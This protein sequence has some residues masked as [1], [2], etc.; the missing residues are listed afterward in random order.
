[1][2]INHESTINFLL[3]TDTY[4]E[5]N[6]FLNFHAAMNAYRHNRLLDL[7]FNIIFAHICRYLHYEGIKRAKKMNYS[8][9]AIA[10]IQQNQDTH[11]MSMENIE[12][13]IRSS[14]LNVIN[15]ACKANKMAREFGL[16][17]FLQVKFEKTDENAYRISDAR[18]LAMDIA[19]AYEVYLG[20]SIIKV[21]WQ[22][23]IRKYFNQPKA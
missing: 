4:D 16:E 8:S 14:L 20:D 18:K 9:D 23:R 13:V 3:A 17:R 19:C 11:A 10:F 12:N 21:D 2:A 15:H 7:E 5:K 1:M 22:E 6:S